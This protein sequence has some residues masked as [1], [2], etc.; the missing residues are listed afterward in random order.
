MTLCRS[1]TTKYLSTTSRKRE[2][3]PF[4]VSTTVAQRCFVNYPSQRWSRARPLT[5][6]I[7]GFAMSISYYGHCALSVSQSQRLI[8]YVRQ[9]RPNWFL[10]ALSLTDSKPLGPFGAEIATKFGIEAQCK[11]AL[12]VLD[13]SRLQMVHPAVDYLYEI[14][15]TQNLLVSWELDKIRPPKTVSAGLVLK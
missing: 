9:T 11:F 3:K 14:F 4:V 7:E 12:H 1:D 6:T 8:E 13:K 10:G 5:Q 2:V 15:G